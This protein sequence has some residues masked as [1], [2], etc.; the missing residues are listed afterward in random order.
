MFNKF[1]LFTFAQSPCNLHVNRI[2]HIDDPPL[3]FK[4]QERE[5]QRSESVTPKCAILVVCLAIA[6]KTPVANQRSKM[7]WAYAGK[8]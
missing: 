2:K 3:R 8:T 7:A 5:P 4:R 6:A 1:S